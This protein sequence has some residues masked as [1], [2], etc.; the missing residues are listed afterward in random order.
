MQEALL[1]GSPI[2]GLP[3][4]VTNLAERIHYV[5]VF[6]SPP[7]GGFRGFA[8]AK[9][10][11]SPGSEES[12]Q[13]R[14][15]SVYGA[16]SI[17]GLL[18]RTAEYGGDRGIIVDPLAAKS[19]QLVEDMRVKLSTYIHGN[20]VGFLGRMTAASTPTSSAT[21]TLRSGSDLRRFEKD[22]PLQTE[23]TGATGGTV[24]PGYVIVTAVGTEANPT[25]TVSGANWAAGIPAVAASDYLYLK[26]SYDDAPVYGFDAWLPDHSGSPGTFLG[27][28][29]N[30]M[31]ERLAG[32]VLDGTNM[33]AF[34]RA[35][36]AARL[37]HDAGGRPDTYLMSTRNYEAL[38]FELQ[39]QGRLR[40]SK[41]PASP[42]GK[43][44]LG[45][46]YDCIELAVPGGTMKVFCDPFMPDDVE[47]CGQRDTMVLGSLG[48]LIH[49]DEQAG[50]SNPMLEDAQD[51]KEIRAIGDIAFWIENPAFWCRVAV[52]A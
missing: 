42:V 32:K 38:T 7:I 43:I 6:T 51:A 17:E 46:D 27:V 20:G 10:H 52:T 19:K 2:L 4:K 36:R 23:S 45:I 41:E 33:S 11:K 9:Q 31:P 49:W 50:P 30:T 48:D 35:T 21:I 47:R 22:M 24:N 39:A 13:V 40:F 37:V 16:F 3:R 44:K 8:D 15:K 29:R 26:G 1:K 18:W 12:F 25:I 28:N 14:K 5:P 34:Q